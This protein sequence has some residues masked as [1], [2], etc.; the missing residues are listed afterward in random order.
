MHSHIRISVAHHEPI[1]FFFSIIHMQRYKSHQNFMLDDT[2][3]YFP[4]I[5]NRVFQAVQ[6]GIVRHYIGFTRYIVNSFT[7]K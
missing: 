6:K 4:Q 1:G 7:V 2:R 3:F 5:S